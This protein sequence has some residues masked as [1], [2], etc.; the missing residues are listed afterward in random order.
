MME[1]RM[2]LK[3]SYRLVLIIF[4]LVVSGCFGGAEKTEIGETGFYFVNLGGYQ[5]F[6][7]NGEEEVVVPPTVIGS[8]KL[9]NSYV[10]VRQVVQEYTCS[11]SLRAE[12]TG[13]FEYWILF[14]QNKYVLAGPLSEVKL[15]LLLNLSNERWEKLL[16]DLAAIKEKKSSLPS[17]NDCS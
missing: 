5:R 13:D 3:S 9:K 12:I 11:G 14:K 17:G 15:H 6:L 16:S 2:L 1:M 10:F 7:A 4:L 8:V